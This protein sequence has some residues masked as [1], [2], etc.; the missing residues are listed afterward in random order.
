VE[1]EL[2]LTGC[3]VRLLPRITPWRS[4]NG[5]GVLYDWCKDITQGVA[6]EYMDAGV[7]PVNQQGGSL[8]GDLKSDF[9]NDNIYFM[10]LTMNWKF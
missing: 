4:Q 2:L 9:K 6:F 10:A 3:V 5:V 8:R 7:A 1:Q